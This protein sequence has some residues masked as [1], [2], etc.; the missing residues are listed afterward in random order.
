[1]RLKLP[2]LTDEAAIPPEDRVRLEL[3]ATERLLWAGAPIPARY[4]WQ[5]GWPYF[6]MS[7]PWLVFFA[8]WEWLLLAKA[9]RPVWIMA[10]AGIPFILGGLGMLVRPFWLRLEARRTTYGITTDRAVIASPG[11]TR[12]FDLREMRG[13]DLRFGKDGSGSLYFGA[14]LVPIRSH[15]KHI[16]DEDSPP[17]VTMRKLGFVALPEVREVEAILERARRGEALLGTAPP[18]VAQ[19]SRRSSIPAA[20]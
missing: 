3:H 5:L 9:P 8:Y 16:A 19:T 15:H 13:I 17:R 6:L 10:V 4:G 12:S 2:L 20:G 14:E 1:M 7:V 11:R 18:L